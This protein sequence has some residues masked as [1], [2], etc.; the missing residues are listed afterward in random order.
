MQTS[1]TVNALFS[2][3]SAHVLIDVRKPTARAASGAGIPDAV[4]RHPFDAANWCHDHQ[5]HALVVFCVHGHEVSQAVAGFLRDEGINAVFLE[6]GFAAWV[7][8]GRPVEVL[9]VG[10]A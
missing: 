7:A 1:I 10:N 3:C 6:G 2:E 4:W 9:E 8:S 5:G